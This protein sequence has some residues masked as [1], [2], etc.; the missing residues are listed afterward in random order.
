MISL[1]NNDPELRTEDL[2]R[3]LAVVARVAG[4][5]GT[6][7]RSDKGLVGVEPVSGE[8]MMVSEVQQ[9]LKDTG[10]LPG[11]DVDGI[12]GYRTQ[13]AIRLFQEYVRSI[14]ETLMEV[15]WDNRH[16]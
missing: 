8:P 12:C 4:D 14:E 15:L 3:Y 1:G 5:S 7:L 10:F 9:C 2:E 13:S 6:K 11:G 16:E